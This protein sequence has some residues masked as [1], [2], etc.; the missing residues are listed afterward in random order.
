V[1]ALKAGTNIAVL[2]IP[3]RARAGAYRLELTV[4]TTSGEARMLKRTVRVPR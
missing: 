3:R 2:K 4:S 1:F